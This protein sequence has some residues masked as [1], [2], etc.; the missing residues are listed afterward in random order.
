MKEDIRDKLSL[1][2][3]DV[4]D[5][6]F[7]RKPGSYVYRRHYRMGLRSHIMELLSPEDLGKE[8]HGVVVEG[9]KTFPKAKPIKMLRIFRTKFASLTDARQ[10]LSRVKI[11]EAYLAPAHMARSDEFLVSYLVGGKVELLL[12]GVQEYV[13]GETLDPWAALNEDHLLSF[14]KRMGLEGRESPE[15][16]AAQ[17]I[18][19]V[20]EKA[21]HFLGRLR[22]MVME[23]GH[24]PDLA[25]VGNLLLTAGGE[26]KLVDINNIS[27]VH[28]DTRIALDDRGYPVCDKSIQALFHMEQK[29]LGRPFNSHDVIRKTFLDPGRVR[30]VKEA[31]ERFHL[32]VEPPVD[33]SLPATP[34]FSSQLR[35]N[36]SRR[37]R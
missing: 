3:D 20:R 18:R 26:I 27:T 22:A 19:K 35:L 11:V 10:E 7:I 29:L 34:L 30:D 9:L 14:Y 13:E 16:T 37:C 33:P 15:K 25:G 21:D 28:F 6:N 24:V 32:S 5:L 36:R 12:C 8:N 1:S 23:A 31:V 4:L 17:W 2:H